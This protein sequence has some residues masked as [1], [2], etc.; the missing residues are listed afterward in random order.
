MPIRKPKSAKKIIETI[1][2]QNIVK[3]KRPIGELY[4]EVVLRIPKKDLKHKD[5]SEINQKDLYYDVS[6]D[7]NRFKSKTDFEKISDIEKTIREDVKRL[8][9]STLIQIKDNLRDPL[10]KDIPNSLPRKSSLMGIINGYKKKGLTSFAIAVTD[11][12]TGKVMGYTVIRLSKAAQEFINS[13]FK[14]INLDTPAGDKYFRSFAEK[15]AVSGENAEQRYENH[16]K[17]L[18]NFQIKHKT[19][20]GY[21]LDPKTRD[22]RKKTFKEKLGIFKK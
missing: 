10:I 12:K 17:D 20:P 4:P 16:L 6:K 9:N 21:I 5:I 15:I 14:K 7:V 11:S 13:H 19:M 18:L 8:D 2:K 1:V 22:F 3:Q